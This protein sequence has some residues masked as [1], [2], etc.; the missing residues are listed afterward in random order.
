MR[1][2]ISDKEAQLESILRLIEGLERDLVEMKQN[3]AA[4]REQAAKHEKE[5]KEASER[6]AATID[7]RRAHIQG[8]QDTVQPLGSLIKTMEEEELSHFKQMHLREIEPLRE[9]NDVLRAEVQSLHQEII[10]MQERMTNI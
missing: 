1:T 4:L 6:M 9:G 2:A 3:L 8:L 10:T 7:D 5:S